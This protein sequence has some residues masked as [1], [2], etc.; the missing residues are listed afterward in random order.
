MTPASAVRSLSV[1]WVAAQVLALA[2]C[3]AVRR[4]AP[5]ASSAASLPSSLHC[6][7]F[8]CRCPRMG[9]LCHASLCFARAAPAAVQEERLPICRCFAAKVRPRDRGTNLHRLACQIALTCLPRSVRWSAVRGFPQTAPMEWRA[10]SALL[11]RA[12]PAT[13][14]GSAAQCGAAVQSAGGRRCLAVALAPICAGSCGANQSFTA[15]RCRAPGR[16]R[17]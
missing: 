12:S 3:A 17:C 10:C 7:C 8:A 9:Q 1:H 15:V 14:E 13:P 11:G 2:V 4:A 5:I 16:W 6:P